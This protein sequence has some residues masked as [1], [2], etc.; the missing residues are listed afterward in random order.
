MSLALPHRAVGRRDDPGAFL[1]C[2]GD[3][4]GRVEGVD[5]RMVPLEV[6]QKVAAALACEGGQGVVVQCGKPA[7]CPACGAGQDRKATRSLG[8][9][10]PYPDDL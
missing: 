3:L 1:P 8:V 4:V 2:L 9:G 6:A 10:S 7:D 5:A